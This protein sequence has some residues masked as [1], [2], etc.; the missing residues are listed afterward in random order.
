MLLL[1]RS[2]NLGE[3]LDRPQESWVLYDCQEVQPKISLVVSI[4]NIVWL[5]TSRKFMKKPNIL[6]QC[7]NYGTGF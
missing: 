6:L 2:H 7:I 5:Y 3:D 4:S 1:K